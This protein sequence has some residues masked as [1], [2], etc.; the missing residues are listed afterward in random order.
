MSWL[1]ADIVRKVRPTEHIER[2]YRQTIAEVPRLEGEDPL[3]ARRREMFYMNLT[4]FLPFLLERKDRMSMATGFEARVPFCDYRLVEY[5]WNI[6]WEM[7]TVDAI[8]KGILR[9][10]F[11]NVLPEDAR[12]R[13][14]SAYPSAQN[15][16]YDEATRDWT[17]QILNDSNAAIQPLLDLQVARTLVENNAAGLQ[18]ITVVS[19]Y[20]HIIQMNEW[21]E[22]YQ[23]T[24]T[25]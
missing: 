14:K 17:L 21:L 20:E 5:V 12:N 19:L 24:L 22:K 23:V 6:P 9:R 16:A 15:P 3:E 8:E 13:K 25:L 1:S 2:Q 18:G 10:A 4:C 7:K 11:A